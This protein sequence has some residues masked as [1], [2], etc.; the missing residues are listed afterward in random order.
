MSRREWLAASAAG[1]LAAPASGWFG[2]VASAA[3]SSRRR[4]CILLWMSGGPTQTDT[5]DMKPEHA[6]GGPFRPLLTTVPG[7]EFS[8][9]LPRLAIQAEHLAVLRSMST[10]EGDHQ[11]ATFKMRTGYLP[12]GPIHYP[13]LGS[14][15]SKELSDG[16][17]PL[18]GFI[19]VAP[20][21][22]LS[23]AAFGPGFLG[24]E[25]APL[26][27]GDGNPL[28]TAVGGVPGGGSQGLGV[29]NLQ[30]AVGLDRRRA[31]ARLG[32]LEKLE[33]DFGAERPDVPA[34]SHRSAYR[35]AVRMMRSESV[36]AF[37]LDSEPASLRDAYG[38]SRF[39]QGCLLARRLVER[40]VPFVEVSLNGVD[41][42]QQLGWDTHQN[43]FDTVKSLS[44][45][46]DSGWATLLEDLQL[47]GLLETTLVIWMG[48]FGRTPTINSNQGRD[49]FPGAWTTVLAGGGVRGGQVVGRTSADGG[50]VSDRPIST[51][52]LM[53][54]VCGALGVD[55][56]RQNMSNVGRPIRLVDP[57]SSVVEGVL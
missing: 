1:V 16:A 51:G 55:S 28:P 34:R 33:S 38:R 26:V 3:A 19:S 24:P 11:R 50:E 44:S 30:Q 25:Y 17:S 10:K 47:R 54:T 49:H 52:D 35:Q 6:N 9:H 53:A 2:Q 12:Q 5:F 22:F 21:R 29:R 36:S 46:L 18:P 45:T 14:M 7:L 39:G 23:P 32:L 57:E 4:S 15:L 48:E 8:Q 27:V 41:G 40:G 37:K 13:T 43:N 20:Y 42:Q 56:Q 31:D